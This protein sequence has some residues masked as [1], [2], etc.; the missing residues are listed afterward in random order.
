MGSGDRASSWPTDVVVDR[1]CAN[2]QELQLSLPQCF[3]C[4]PIVLCSSATVNMVR[5]AE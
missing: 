4:I 5:S 2:D 3:T 1:L